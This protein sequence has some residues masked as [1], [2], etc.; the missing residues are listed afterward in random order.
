MLLGLNRHA[1]IAIAPWLMAGLFLGPVVVG[2]LGTWLPA[3]GYLPALGQ[4]EFSLTPLI[5]F[6]NYPGV[7]KAFWLS[8][9][10][11]LFSSLLA[12][13]SV[14][15][16]LLGLYPSTIFKKLERFLAPIL[17][18]PHAAFAIG[19]GFLITPSGWFFRAIHEV[20]GWFN[21]PPII[22]TLQDSEGLSLTLILLLKETPFLLFMALATLP[23]LKVSKTLWLGASLGYSKVFTW[24]WLLFPQLYQ[25]LRLPFYS[26][27]AYS[28]SVVDIS[29]IAGPTAPPTAAVMITRL[30][31]DADLSHRFLGAVGAS[32]LLILVLVCLLG[33]RIIEQLLTKLRSRQLAKGNRRKAPQKILFGLSMTTLLMLTV[34]YFFSLTVTFLWSIAQRWRYPDIFPS[35]LTNTSWLRSF[36][37]LSETLTTTFSIALCSAVLAVI[38]CLLALENE[39]RLRYKYS[40]NINS[41]WLLLWL[42]LPLLVPQVAFLFGFQVSLIYLNLDGHWLAVLWSHL[43]FVIP[44]VFLTLSEP[45][46]NYDDRYSYI[47]K[48]LS[49]QPIR[50]YFK[51]KFTML[52]RPILYA[53]AIGFSVSIAQY[54]PT[55]FV[56]AGHYA[57]ITTEAVAM[58]SGSNR[59]MIAVLAMWQQLLPLAIFT[60]AIVIPAIRFRQH[61]SMSHTE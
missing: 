9:S 51:I 50:A 11:G 33:V 56:G 45:Y 60:L 57:T 1:W 14:F 20:T 16:L 25:R 17:S 34:S 29:I 42:Y 12:L 59:R 31:T 49:G 3:A 58:T 18:I 41:S 8:L 10:T 36:D 44:Y 43:V 61:R 2:L 38:L 5:S 28:L 30:F 13:M 35:A 26:V 27:I 6:T 32:A 22:T 24:T 7:G 40:H 47:A 4:S 39:V 48:S 54:L 23:T 19:F 52:L 15:I 46:R 21:R 53:F 55:L 37:R